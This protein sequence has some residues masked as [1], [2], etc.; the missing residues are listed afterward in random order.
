MLIRLRNCGFS[1][2]RNTK[3]AMTIALTISSLKDSVMNPEI[4]SL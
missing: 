3:L 1:I 4:G 2:V